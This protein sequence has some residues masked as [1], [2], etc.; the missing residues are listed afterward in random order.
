M[1]TAWTKVNKIEADEKWAVTQ[2]GNGFKWTST[3]K[4]ACLT[5]EREEGC[6]PPEVKITAEDA[7]VCVTLVGSIAL[8]Q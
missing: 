3:E 1:S 8:V 5:I 7:G 4:G 6:D 2:V